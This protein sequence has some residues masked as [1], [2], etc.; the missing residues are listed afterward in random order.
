MMESLNSDMLF[1]R[2]LVAFGI[3]GQF[4]LPGAD[5][6]HRDDMRYDGVE[7]RWFPAASTQPSA[8]FAV[9]GGLAMRRDGN[10]RR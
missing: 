9:K 2:E 3:E 10:E 8:T 1:C 5:S 7:E 6:L 4:V